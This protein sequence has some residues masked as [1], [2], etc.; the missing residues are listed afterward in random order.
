MTKVKPIDHRLTL[1]IPMWLIEAIDK[2]R[3][4]ESIMQSR[5]MWI[6]KSLAQYL[7]ILEREQ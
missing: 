7:E 6:I 2:E 3:N 1:R 4:K 5:N